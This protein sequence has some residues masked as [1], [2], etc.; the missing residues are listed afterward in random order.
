[1]INYLSAGALAEADNIW[2]QLRRTME[3][4]EVELVSIQDERKLWSSVRQV[5]VC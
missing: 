5:L 4:F 2:A 3:R 1:M